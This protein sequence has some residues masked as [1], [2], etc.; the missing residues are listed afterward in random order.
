MEI[1]SLWCL[2]CIGP[3]IIIIL[4]FVIAGILRLVAIKH[5]G[6]LKKPG[7]K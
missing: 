6:L 2:C 4:A 5:P 3:S 7:E 1:F